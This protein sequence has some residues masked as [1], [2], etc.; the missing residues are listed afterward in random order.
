MDKLGWR[1]QIRNCVIHVIQHVGRRTV[2]A[3]PLFRIH[4]TPSPRRKP[5][6]SPPVLIAEVRAVSLIAWGKTL[7]TPPFDSRMRHVKDE[8]LEMG[9]LN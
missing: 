1:G 5:G 9:H 3:Q 4:L 6:Y 2:I 7:S 8:V